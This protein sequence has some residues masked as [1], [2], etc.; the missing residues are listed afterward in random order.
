MAGSSASS[1]RTTCATRW[2]R[3]ATSNPV[4]VVLDQT[5]FY[6]ESGGQVGDTGELV[7]D[8]FRFEVID[9][10]KEKGFI[11]APRAPQAGRAESERDA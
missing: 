8:G 7:G 4:T 5:P 10:H 1:P 6:G 3:S 11:A 9:T 2:T